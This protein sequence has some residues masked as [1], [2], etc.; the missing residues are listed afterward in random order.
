VG[1]PLPCHQWKEAS[2]CLH[3]KHHEHLNPFP[4]SKLDCLKDGARVMGQRP[5]TH[6]R[7]SSWQG[8]G[9]ED[10][11]V[12]LSGEMTAGQTSQEVRKIGGSWLTFSH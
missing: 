4:L 7:Q 2:H 6:G 5:Y 8:K 9:R 3:R 11:K 1:D 12:E 10:T